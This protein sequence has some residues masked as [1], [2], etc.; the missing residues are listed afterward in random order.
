MPV[1]LKCP[2][3]SSVLRLP[4]SV[5]PGGAIRCPKCKEVLRMPGKAPAPADP[6]M[7]TTPAPKSAA[8][9][10]P[11]PPPRAIKPASAQAPRAKLHAD[12][13]LEDTDD[14]DTPR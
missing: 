4:D 6:P 11:A 8:K 13:I 5:P 12:E 1:Q 10:P 3:C 14:D 9:Q 2:S 7:P